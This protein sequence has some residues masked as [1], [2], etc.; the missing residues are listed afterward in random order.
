MVTLGIIGVVI[1]MTLPIVWEH[2]KRYEYSSKLKKFYSVFQQAIIRSE[3]DNGSA[4]FWAKNDEDLITRKILPYF[5]YRSFK[6][7][8]MIL[9]DGT[10]VWF[11]KGL[12]LDIVADC[13][14]KKKPPNKYGAD[15]F[16]FLMCFDDGSRQ[17]F[18][19]TKNIVFGPS[20]RKKTRAEALHACKNNP[21]NCSAL[22]ECDNWEFKKDY[23]YRLR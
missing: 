19:L 5:D 3:I 7:N 6:N 12:C 14:G 9:P 8:E 22:L 1:A 23:P 13:N 17:Q 16:D 2:Y 21:Q 4:F 11:A 10:W 20:Y 15:R 18:F